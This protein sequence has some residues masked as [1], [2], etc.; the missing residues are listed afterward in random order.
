MQPPAPQ[1]PR[2]ERPAKRLSAPRGHR[3]DQQI[4]EQSEQAAGVARGVEKIR[5]PRPGIGRP[6]KPVLQQRRGRGER[7]ERQADGPCQGPQGPPSRVGPAGLSDVNRQRQH[8]AGGN[9]HA[10]VHGPLPSRR[11]AAAQRVRVEISEQ[12]HGL[13]EDHAGAPDRGAAAEHRQQD[14]ADQRLHD[15]QQRCG[16]ENRQREETPDRHSQKH[17]RRSGAKEIRRRL[18]F[19]KEKTPDLLISWPSCRSSCGRLSGPKKS[20]K[21]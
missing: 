3:L 12:E 13:K 5:I 2:S 1:Q 16:S 18:F 19:P 17:Y 7:E 4:A 21:N 15:E 10:G 11:D 20:A 14:L 6:R 8:D 9:E